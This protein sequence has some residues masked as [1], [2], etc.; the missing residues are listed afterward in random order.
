LR[1]DRADRILRFH[2]SER[3]LHWAIAVPFLVCYTTALVLLVVY[4][5]H[6]ERPYRE[7]VS[8]VHRFSGACL[9]VFPL[10][11]VGLNLKDYRLHLYNIGQGWIWTWKDLKWLL[12]M[13]P[14]AISKKVELPEQGKFNA[15]EKMNFMMV[16]GTYPLYILTGIFIWLPGVA[17]WAWA[18][19]VSMAAIATPLIL[20]HIFMATVN[21]ASRVGLSGMINGWVDRQWAKHHYRAWYRHHFEP[22]RLADKKPVKAVLEPAR[23]AAPRLARV[24][25]KS[26]LGE[27]SVDSWALLFDSAFAA[28]PPSCPDCGSDG[29]VSW[30]LAEEENLGWILSQLDRAGAQRPAI[31]V[32][33]SHSRL[34]SPPRARPE[35]LS[36]GAAPPS[37]EDHGSVAISGR[38]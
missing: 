15:A 36:H 19:H 2:R 5:P 16:M 35:H 12:Y 24:R 18:L 30:V 14:A 8:W 20:G 9:A 22:T 25:C 3:L 26:C 13:V 7:V 23:P 21:P 31:P 32:H 28:E 37:R 1:K 11:A 27:R 33:E 29:A 38:F 10:L 6:P 4:N 34:P 17:F